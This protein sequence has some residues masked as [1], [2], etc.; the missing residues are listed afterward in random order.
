MNLVKKKDLSLQ[1][2]QAGQALKI[3]AKSEFF[4]HQQK[5]ICVK[6]EFFK[7]VIEKIGIKLGIL[8]HRHGII[9]TK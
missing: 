6:P 8:K 3:C 5:N 1:G 9:W 2:G 7:A 4:A